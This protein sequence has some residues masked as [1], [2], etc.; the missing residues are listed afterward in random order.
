MDA[1]F[2][3]FVPG[4]RSIEASQTFTTNYD[5]PRGALSLATF[6]EHHGQPAIVVPLDYF[7]QNTSTQAVIDAQMEAVVRSVIADV[8]PGAIGISAPYTMLYPAALRVAR[9]CKS[10]APNITVGLGG[11]HVTSLDEACFDDSEHV[12]WVARGEGEWTLM[13]VLRRLD[14]GRDL[15]GVAGV[16]YRDEGG[17]VRQNPMRPM[18]SVDLLPPLDY[19]LLPEPFVRTM[20]VS[21]VASRGCAF[22]CTYCNEARFWGQSVRRFAPERVV[23]E[24]RELAQRWGNHAV[25]L[26]DSMFEMGTPYFLELMHALEELPVHPQ[27]YLLSRVDSVHEDGF[28]AMHK[29]G[30]RNLVLGVESASPRVLKKMGKRIKPEQA[31]RALRRAAGSGLT[32]GT[33]WIVGHPGDNPAESDK[34]I[35]AIDQYFREGIMHST[36]IALFVPY[37]GT[38]IYDHPDRFGVEILTREWERWARFRTAPVSQLADFSKEEIQ[39]A[40][41]RTSARAQ[42]WQS[43]RATGLAGGASAKP[44]PCE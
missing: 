1:P 24:I 33:F 19:G 29:A 16:T 2:V 21:I 13:E 43:R 14:E 26:E 15:A 20:A 28:E 44:A 10:Y 3:L 17:Q 27:F 8:Q 11:P 5:F 34:T 32:I 9:W 18:G 36:E 35:C 41:A 42:M 6:L 23:A 4:I 12:D 7:C 31:T 37:P 30:I 39:E 25:G 22:K 38:A 40:W